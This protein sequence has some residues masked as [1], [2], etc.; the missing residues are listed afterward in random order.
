MAAN[1]SSAVTSKFSCVIWPPEYWGTL[2]WN[3]SAREIAERTYRA[4]LGG[5]DCRFNSTGIQKLVVRSLSAIRSANSFPSEKG[6]T[7]D[8]LDGHEVGWIT[9]ACGSAAA[10][11]SGSSTSMTR[12]PAADLHIT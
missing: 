8:R 7:P 1:R 10:H 11:H 3:R 12:V 6:N 2:I 4:F 5:S 9:Q